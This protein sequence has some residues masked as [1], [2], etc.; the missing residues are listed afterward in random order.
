MRP[1]VTVPWRTGTG[2]GTLHLPLYFNEASVS[3]DPTCFI[4]HNIDE[5]VK[6]VL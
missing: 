6:F 4:V 3:Y 1:F 2:I 5:R